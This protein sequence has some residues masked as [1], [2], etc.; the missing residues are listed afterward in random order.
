MP[1][2]RPLP[3]I[4]RIVAVYI[5]QQVPRPEELP[6]FI[7]TSGHKVTPLA[8][9]ADRDKNIKGRCPF[10]LLPKAL[11]PWPTSVKDFRG[12]VPFSQHEMIE[13]FRWWDE[14]TDALAAVNAVWGER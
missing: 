4:A 13:F 6:A 10:G 3:D 1:V 12:G 14:Q 5:R 8:W 7:E 9:P 11:G 2:T